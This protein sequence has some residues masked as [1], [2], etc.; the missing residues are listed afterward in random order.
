MR[1]KKEKNASFFYYYF[2]I[3]W[4]GKGKE[5]ER[6]ILYIY[7]YILIITC[8]SKVMKKNYKNFVS[9]YLCSMWGVNLKGN[10]L[11]WND[12]LIYQYMYFVIDIQYEY[13]YIYIYISK[14]IGMK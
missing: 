6:N 5:I 2:F 11:D 4:F 1:K 8:N 9:L 10:W 12:T 3:I 14:L 7:I 13:I